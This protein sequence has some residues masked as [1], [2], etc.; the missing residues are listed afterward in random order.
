METENQTKPKEPQ[1]DGMSTPRTSV[2]SPVT[3]SGAELA[4][5]LCLS[6]G[7]RATAWAIPLPW[8]YPAQPYALPCPPLET[9]FW[10][11]PQTSEFAWVGFMDEWLAYIPVVSGTGFSYTKVQ[12]SLPAHVFPD[13]NQHEC[14]LRRQ[15]HLHHQK[16]IMTGTFLSTFALFPCSSL[17]GIYHR[18]LISKLYWFR[19]YS[20]G[21]KKVRNICTANVY[22]NWNVFTGDQGDQMNVILV[23]NFLQFK[24]ERGTSRCWA[25]ISATIKQFLQHIWPGISNATDISISSLLFSSMT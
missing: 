10:G 12:M 14:L 2:L 1:E 17:V 20:S 22:I 5:W 24:S 4:V 13:R 21:K 15:A 16:A 19:P 23:S 8:L 18:T 3:V 25:W 6:K 9:S 11:L 7:L